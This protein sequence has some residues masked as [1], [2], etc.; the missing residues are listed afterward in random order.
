MIWKLAN[1]IER[2][3]F[4]SCTRNSYPNYR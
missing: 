3:K 2:F 1:L 4:M